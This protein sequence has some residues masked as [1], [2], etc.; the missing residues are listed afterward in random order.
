LRRA[1][2][3]A[4][5]GN[6]HLLA[7]FEVGVDLFVLHGFKVEHDS[8]QMDNEII[9]T[10][11]NTNGLDNILFL[12]TLITEVILDLLLLCEHLETVLDVLEVLDV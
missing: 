1:F 2:R 8:L 7:E 9:G 12:L 10:I 3:F 11:G 6:V 5:R 4:V